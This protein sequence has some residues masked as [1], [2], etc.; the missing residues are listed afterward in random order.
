MKRLLNSLLVALIS[1]IGE[2]GVVVGREGGGKSR[3]WLADMR[4]TGIPE[5]AMSSEQPTKR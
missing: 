5:V 3:E 2:R 1:V 4:A